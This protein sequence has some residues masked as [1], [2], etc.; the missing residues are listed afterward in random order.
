MV[1]DDDVMF[2]NLDNNGKS[3]DGYNSNLQYFEKER[4]P[5]SEIESQRHTPEIFTTL[6]PPGKTL[7]K[8]IAILNAGWWQAHDNSRLDNDGVMT[9]ED[10][11]ACPF[12]DEG[13]RLTALGTLLELAGHLEYPFAIWREHSAINWEGYHMLQFGSKPSLLSRLMGKKT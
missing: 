7:D 1:H 12:Q 4:V 9:D 10:W 5:E 3:L 11:D 13:E 8:L 2:Y 6:L